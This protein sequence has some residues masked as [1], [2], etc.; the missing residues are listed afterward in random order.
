MGKEGEVIDDGPRLN[1][2]VRVFRKGVDISRIH[3]EEPDGFKVNLE[4]TVK[5]QIPVHRTEEQIN[6]LWLYNRMMGKCNFLY[7]EIILAGEA[8]NEGE[9]S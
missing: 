3:I 1:D 5:I 9:G 6:V 2:G 8:T 4:A 7:A